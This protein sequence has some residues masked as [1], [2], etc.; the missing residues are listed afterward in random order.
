LEVGF[1]S[2]YGAHFLSS[3]IQD[4]TATDI[5]EK[6]VQYA[7][8]RYPSI[9]FCIASGTC[10]PFE[11]ESFDTVVSFQVIEH[12]DDANK[13]VNEIHR[14]LKPGG[15]F[16]LTTPNRRLR[17]L[18]FQ[19]PRNVYHVREYSDRRLRS[20]L[21]EKFP[22]VQISGI[23]AKPD[24][25]A[26]EIA[27]VKQHPFLMLAKML[28]DRLEPILPKVMTDKPIKWYRSKLVC[29][30]SVRREVTVELKDFF[31]SNDVKKCLDLFGIAQKKL[32]LVVLSVRS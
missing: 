3:T 31:I 30:D 24:L 13:Y 17:L 6:A 25:M 7:Q 28:Y 27:R 4:I 20:L 15:W 12:I 14:V 5:S 11:S 21:R 26:L 16:Y 9:R 1:G 2:G 18:P 32:S 23:M 8:S 29:T 19:K 10:L 22:S